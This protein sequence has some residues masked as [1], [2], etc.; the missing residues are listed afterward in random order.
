MR[1]T[2][3]ETTAL[4][5]TRQQYK[6][7]IDQRCGSHWLMRIQAKNASETLARDE[8]Y[9]RIIK[10]PDPSTNGT[11]LPLLPVPN[12]NP[13]NEASMLRIVLAKYR[14]SSWLQSIGTVAAKRMMA[15]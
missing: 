5:A 13:T 8:Q 7:R 2:F 10:L 11:T 4:A 12:I 15:P 6:S 14:N 3:T 1:V 9:G